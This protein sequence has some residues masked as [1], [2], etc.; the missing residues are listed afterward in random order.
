MLTMLLC[1]LVSVAPPPGWDAEAVLAAELSAVARGE[2]W[3]E[4]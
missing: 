3:G 1:H 2:I 4:K